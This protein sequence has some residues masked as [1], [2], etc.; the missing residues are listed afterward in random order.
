MN[1]LDDDASTRT[2]LWV[3]FSAVT[4]LLTSVI[5]WVLKGADGANDV[6]AT[7]TPAAAVATSATDNGQDASTT[8]QE[9]AGNATAQNAV[10]LSQT[11]ALTEEFVAFE[12][13]TPAQPAGAIYFASAS[14]S[15]PADAQQ[16]ITTVVKA[17]RP[18]CPAG[19]LPRP[20]RQ[21]RL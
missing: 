16:A 8:A 6:A 14:A 15:L 11:E 13:A 9:A 7:T 10:S 2:G 5:I 19:W 3:V 1:P 21:H 17:L 12:R 20:H 18:S 4:I